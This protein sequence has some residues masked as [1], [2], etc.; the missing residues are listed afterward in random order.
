MK[1]QSLKSKNSL[2]F[3][4]S[5]WN[6]GD[7][8]NRSTCIVLVAA[9]TMCLM[10]FETPW[11]IRLKVTSMTFIQT[12]CVGRKMVF[13]MGLHYKGLPTCLTHKRTRHVMSG[14]QMMQNRPPF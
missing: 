7:L 11:M 4:V 6:G 8:Y 12:F 14:N 9:I 3:L 1:C 5:F 13:Q 2:L 10:F